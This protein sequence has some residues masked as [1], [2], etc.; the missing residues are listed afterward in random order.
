MDKDVIEAIDA[1]KNLIT[2]RTVEGDVLNDY[3]TLDLTF[4]AIP[5]G[6]GCLVHVTLE[7]EKLKSHISDPYTL[8]DVTAELVRD[9]DAHL[10]A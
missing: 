5:K 9:I 4:H 8:L 2:L 10:A 6:K 1:N 7:Y 3:K